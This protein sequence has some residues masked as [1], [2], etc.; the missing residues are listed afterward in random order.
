MG[1]VDFMLNY[2][3]AGNDPARVVRCVSAMRFR[4]EARR[5]RY[6]AIVWGAASAG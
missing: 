6:D 1:M 2:G 3:L 4:R 5:D